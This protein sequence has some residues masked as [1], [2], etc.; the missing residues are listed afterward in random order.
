[1]F[2]FLYIFRVSLELLIP[3]CVKPSLQ[4]SIFKLQVT[5]KM[6]LRR[7]LIFRIDLGEKYGKRTGKRGKILRGNV[8]LKTRY[9]I[10][11]KQS[12]LKMKK[13]R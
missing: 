13:A 8:K 2:H 4:N 5:C 12:K 6:V 7:K 10:N 9:E 1:M 11:A 3:S